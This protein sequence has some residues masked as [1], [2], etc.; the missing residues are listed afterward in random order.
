MSTSTV[1]PVVDLTDLPSLDE[2]AAGVGVIETAEVAPSQSGEYQRV[3]L[4]VKYPSPNG[5]ERTQHIRFNLKPEWLTAAFAQQVR[6]GLVDDNTA[7]QYRINIAGLWRGLFM[8]AGLSQA[9]LTLLPGKTVGFVVDYR[10]DKATGLPKNDSPEIQKFVEP[11][12]FAQVKAKLDKDAADRRAKLGAAGAGPTA[13]NT[14]AS[15]AGL[16]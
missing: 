5:T 12:K 15:P 13:P 14:A 2:P 10:Y 7:L 3:H 8:S 9:D 6:A 16:L 1:L 11:A 4:V